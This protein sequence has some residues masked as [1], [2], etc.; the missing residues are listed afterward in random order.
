ML[1]VTWTKELALPVVVPLPMSPSSLGPVEL[2][3]AAAAALAEGRIPKLSIRP[4]SPTA[5]SLERNGNP[6][7]YARPAIAANDLR[8]WRW[9]GTPK[10]RTL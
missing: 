9:T 4:E 1:V 8:I 10:W 6:A 3:S 7:K 2:Q 5:D